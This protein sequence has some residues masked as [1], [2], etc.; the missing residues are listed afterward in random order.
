MRNPYLIILAA[1]CVAPS[2]LVATPRGVH[3]QQPTPVESSSQSKPLGALA[4][5][6]KVVSVQTPSK[7]W[8]IGVESPG[9]ASVRQMQP[10]R[11]ELY[12]GEA[13]ITESAAGYNSIKKTTDG[14]VGLAEITA[15]KGVVFRVEDRW[16]IA[17][18]VLS[19][20]RNVTISGNAY[21]GFLSGITLSTAGNFSFPDVDLFI[22]GTI[23]GGPE[24]LLDRAA[25]GPANYRTGRVETRE[26]CLPIPLLGVSF[27]DGTSIAVLDPQ[28]RGDTTAAEARDLEGTTLIDERFL[29]GALG[30]RANRDGGIDF[31]FWFPGT[32]SWVTSDFRGRPQRSWRRRY[33]P[34]RDGLTQHYQVAFR[35]GRDEEF[36]EFYAKAWRWGWNSLQPA[37]NYYDMEVVRRALIDQLAGR[38]VTRDGRTGIPFFFDTITSKPGNLL[39]DTDAIMGFVGK[40]LEAAALLLQDADRDATP[41]GE[42]HRQLGLAIIDTFVRNLKVA[43]PEGEGFNLDTGLPSL[44]NPKGNFVTCCNGRVYLR[45]LTDDLRWTLKAYQRELKQ[46]REHREWLRWSMEF[47]EWLLAQQRPDG[48]FTRSWY[49]GTGEIYDSASTSSYNAMAFLVTLKQ[50]TGQE[51]FLAAALRTGDFC[52]MTYHSRDQ[53]VGGTLDNPNIMDKEAGTLSLEGYLALYEATRDPQWLHRAQAAA[54]FAE[55]WIYGW[56]VPMPVDEDDA[57]L[58]WKKGVSTVG[59]NRINST[60][61]GVDQWMAGDV[62]EYARL[63]KYTKDSHYLDIARILLHNTKNMVALPGRTYDLVGPGWQQEHWS[64]AIRRGFGGHRGA[65]PWVTVNHLTGIMALEDF[66]PALFQ[67]L[68]SKRETQ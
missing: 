4:T 9:L 58:H 26:D 17:G 55:T 11:L 34:I 33:H 16:T 15:L 3:S 64:M 19:V 28:P 65:L 10:V 22:P 44:T 56:S 60:G 5:G 51:R 57:A 12:E 42:K 7:E 47:G 24:H 63:Y 53:Y 6:A 32:V 18:S 35:F 14:F 49:P 41:R 66:D 38:V 20:A 61:C 30:A 46:G 40:N 48:S 67:Q 27:R 50:V 54:D 31:G 1:I 13:K 68:A 8:G 43:P 37:V 62:D 2:N 59:V 25:G 39:R 29:F 21:G 52:W 36:H 23:Y 45:A